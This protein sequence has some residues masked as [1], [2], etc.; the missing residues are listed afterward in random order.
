MSDQLFYLVGEVHNFG[1]FFGGD[2]V[3]LTATRRAPPPAIAEAAGEEETLTIDQAALANVRDRHT[4]MAG[5]LLALTMAGDRVDQAELLG[6][7]T[8]AELRAALGPPA[9]DGPLDGPRILSYHCDSCGLWVA[10]APADGRCRLC[11]ASLG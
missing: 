7:A 6:A 2:T 11:G 4:I 3:T 8:H 5:M 1:G 10:L 9:V